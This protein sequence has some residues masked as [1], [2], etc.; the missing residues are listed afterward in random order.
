MAAN[1]VTYGTRTAL[2][3]VDRL[4]SNVA[5]VAEAFGEIVGA[6]EL[7]LNVHITI[8]IHA[9]ATN[10]SYDLYLVES[11]DGV[12]WT[13]NIDPATSGDV[14]AKLND[15]TF[16]KSASTIYNATNRTEARFHINL[17]MLTNAKYV[18]FVLVNK[19]SQT[20]PAAGSDGD[21]V[22]IKIAV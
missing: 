10:G 20:I 22:T 5:G 13:D 16:I 15:A 8:P 7:G 3:N 17:S 9:S 19:S 2:S 6:G 18:G 14:A 12:E 21:S 1:D 11:Q 4:N